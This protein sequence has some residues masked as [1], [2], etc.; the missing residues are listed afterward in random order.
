MGNPK[1]SSVPTTPRLTP[2]AGTRFFV[3]IVLTVGSEP[4]EK[5]TGRV[6]IPLPMAGLLMAYGTVSLQ[7]LPSY[8]PDLS[9]I[10]P[11]PPLFE[12]QAVGT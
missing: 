9:G 8:P 4:I 1:P 2:S 6:R 11:K 3:S 12:F 10:Q 7:T 5:K